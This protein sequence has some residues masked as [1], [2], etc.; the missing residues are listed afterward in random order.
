MIRTPVMISGTMM[1][2]I[3]FLVALS[4]H[5]IAPAPAYAAPASISTH[6]QAAALIDVHS[7]RI[8]YSQSGDKQMR[9]ASLTKIM[10][11]IVAIE[12]GNLSDKVKVSKQAYGVEGSSIYLKLGE[13]MS[14][15][16]LLYGLMLRSGNDAAVAIAEHVG[17]S[18][19]GFVYLMNA[20][21]QSIGMAN[22]NFKNPHGLDIEGHYS[23]ANDMAKL[24]A[25]A[26]RNPIFQ[27]IVKTKMKTVPNPYESW[28]NRWF[29][30]NKMLKLYEGADGVKTGY[31][32]LANRCL[33]SSATRNGQQFA[34][35]TLS[36]GD[37]WA[38]H[39]KLLDYGFQ[40]FQEH[41]IVNKGEAIKGKDLVAGRSFTY[42]LTEEERT[43][44]SAKLI[45]MKSKTIPD[46]MGEKG[47][48][49]IYLED[50]RIAAIPL[51]AINSPRLLINEQN[52][53]SQFGSVKMSSN[54]LSFPV[55][56]K[57][58]FKG[59]FELNS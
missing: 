57:S 33:V 31:T 9:I 30:K 36:D 7:G 18:L 13:E 35:V 4:F 19:E 10:T 48:L 51:Y 24:S 14:L 58:I 39:G 37:D 45:L 38:D 43:R 1:L 52:A 27:D 28:D 49:H 47:F 29:N 12:H 46:L 20:K 55:I 5:N 32:K 2:V 44:I 41:P 25:Y 17:G 22:S 21:A 23:T 56:F 53:I 15:Q 26:L 40:Y 42:P 3:F 54:H 50:T 34:V 8:V 11:A 6:A 16:H 59:L